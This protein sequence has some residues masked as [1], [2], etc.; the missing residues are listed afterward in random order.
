MYT[1]TKANRRRF[2]QRQPT[3]P[4][5]K[6]MALMAA[7]VPLGYIYYVIDCMVRR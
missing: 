3:D 1:I 2:H 6:F 7:S 4:C 5:I